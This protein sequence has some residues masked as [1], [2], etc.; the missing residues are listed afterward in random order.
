MNPGT[1][2]TTPLMDSTQVF[3]KQSYIIYRHSLQ[4]NKN[5]W[6]I[7]SLKLPLTTDTIILLKYLKEEKNR[8]DSLNLEILLLITSTITQRA[9]APIRPE[10]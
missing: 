7:F 10:P 8:D 4:A 6:S 2:P 1:G 9:V 3:M 5:I